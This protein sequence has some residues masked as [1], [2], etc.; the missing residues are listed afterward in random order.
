LKSRKESP[1]VDSLA[2]EFAHHI[3]HTDLF[4]SAWGTYAL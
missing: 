3:A 4:H 2:R 1:L